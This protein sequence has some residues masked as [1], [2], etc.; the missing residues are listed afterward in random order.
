MDYATVMNVIRENVKNTGAISKMKTSK[1]NRGFTIITFK[2]RYNSTCSLQKSSIGTEDC[3]W[4]GPD[5]ANPQ[6]MASD[7]KRLGIATDKTTGH[8]NYP[9]PPQVHLTT[10][11]HLTQKQVKAL[12]PTLIKF[13]ET[14]EI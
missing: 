12:L 11:M 7:A 3:I 6:I 13:V 1:T 5:F 8:I 2:D 9:L 4:F 14:G 10:R